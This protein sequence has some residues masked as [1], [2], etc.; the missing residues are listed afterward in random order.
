M[1]P[2]FTPSTRLFAWAA[3]CSTALACA[4][5]QAQSGTRT[6]PSRTYRAPS[7]STPNYNAPPV[8]RQ[9]MPRQVVQRQPAAAGLQGYCPV[10]VI[11]MK[12][13]VKGKPSIQAQYDGKTYYFPAEDQR[14]K[15]LADP[16]KYAP[17]LGGDCAVCRINMNKKM[18]GSVQYTALHNDR[19]F[20]FPNADIKKKFMAEPNRYAD[21]DL[22]L[23]GDCAVCK[24][25]MKQSVPGKPE[26]STTHGG[27]R[28][29]FPSDKQRN[30]F[31]ANPA[32]YSVKSNAVN[33][34]GSGTRG[35]GTR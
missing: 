31:I 22:A 1:M 26:F 12:K 8:P 16:A 35:S 21:A 30:M 32:K 24:V 34:S 25:E 10:C 4:H 9:V 7:Y 14:Q 19:L 28:Y 6:A 3:L 27:M 33:A 13:W 17:A 5:V 20:L 15:F 2:R 11:E 18:P 29:Q 23:G